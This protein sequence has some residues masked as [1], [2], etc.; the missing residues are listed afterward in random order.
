[1][2]RTVQTLKGFGTSVC[3]ARGWVCWTEENDPISGPWDFDGLECLVVFRFPLI[4]YRAVHTF[5]WSNDATVRGGM[6]GI[7]YWSYDQIPIRWSFAL[8][9][10]VALRRWI[11]VALAVG[12]GCLFNSQLG[13]PAPQSVFV[14]LAV[15]CGIL[16]GLGILGWCWMAVSESRVRRIR[17][18]LGSHRRGSSDPATWTE[19]DL[20]EV[21]GPQEAYGSPTFADAVLPLL[22]AGQL[23]K[24][25]WAARLTVAKEDR[26]RGERLTSQVLK[27]PEVRKALAKVEENPTVWSSVMQQEGSDEQR[28]S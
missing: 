8:L 9:I 23:S 26:R 18:V 7:E 6:V 24:A 27:H 14:A 13:R 12:I 10:R 19:E 28:M 21:V 3:G 22:V 17:R 5:N 20:R 16:V 15:A 11:F 1:M 4:P 2:R 25:M